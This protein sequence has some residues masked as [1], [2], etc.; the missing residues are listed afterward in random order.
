M[1][2]SRQEC[3]KQ[4]VREEVNRNISK[5]LVLRP[6]PME[7]HIQPATKASHSLGVRKVRRGHGAMTKGSGVQKRSNVV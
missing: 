6:Q 3:A 1:D 2:R 5:T 7:A 4:G